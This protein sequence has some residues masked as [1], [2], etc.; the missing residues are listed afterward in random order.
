M[1]KDVQIII[2]AKDMASRALGSFGMALDTTTKKVTALD[3]QLQKTA[4]RADQFGR[5]AS[6]LLTAPLLAVG[7]ASVKAAADME[8]STIALTTLTGS[9][10]EANK[11]L[12]AIKKISLESKLTFPELVDASRKMLAY[13]FTVK[14]TIPMIKI[15]GDATSALGL[16]KE[17]IDR[18]TIALGQ[19]QAKSIVSAEEMRQLS[20]AGIGAWKYLADAIGVSVPEAM[21]MAEKRMIDGATGIKAILQGMANDPKF[22]DGMKKQADSIWGTWA[23]LQD[24]L[25]YSAATVGAV[26]AK[27]FDLKNRLKGATDW[28]KDFA[29]G[30]NKLNPA[31]KGTIVNVALFLVA[32][33]PVSMVV[34]QA[35]R[36]ISLLIGLL[37]AM[38]VASVVTFIKN[39]ITA[40][41][42]MTAGS[43]AAAYGVIF[44][45]RELQ[46][47]ALNATIV[48][49]IIGITALVSN[50]AD[51]ARICAIQ[52][53]N[54][55]NVEDA[56]KRIK[57]L[58]ELKLTLEKDLADQENKLLTGQQFDAGQFS[59]NGV[60]KYGDPNAV[61][62][63]SED[64]RK[65]AIDALK[66]RILEVD[67]MIKY[68]NVKI[69]DIMNPNLGENEDPA[70]KLKE[71]L[72]S[73]TKGLG[74]LSA[75]GGSK[76]TPADII[77]DLNTELTA[78]TTKHKLLG[79]EFD[80]ITANA[81][82]YKKAI[83]DMLSIDPNNSNL[84]EWVNK[85]QYYQRYSSIENSVKMLSDAAK[86]ELEWSDY[87][88]AYID[89]KSLIE[90][91]QNAAL[92][93][94][95]SV[96]A[97]PRYDEHLGAYVT[98]EVKQGMQNSVLLMKQ[99]TL[100]AEAEAERFK[101]IWSTSLNDTMTD[102]DNW[103]LHMVSIMAETAQ[104]MSDSFSNLFFDT[105]TG[106]FK[107]LSSYATSFVQSIAKSVTDSLGQM[108]TKNIMSGGFG[109][110]LGSQLNTVGNTAAQTANSAAMTAN[111]G[112]V[113]A[114][115][116]QNLLLTSSS[117]SLSTIFSSLTAAATSAAAALS[118]IAVT[119]GISG[120]FA[121]GGYAVAGNAY[122]VGERGPEVFVP[123][124]SGTVIPN[125]KL[126][127]LNS[128]SGKT[129]WNVSVINQTGVEAEKPT[130]DIDLET[131]QL[132]V[133]LKAVKTNKLGTRD[134]LKSFGGTR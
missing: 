77:K 48:G 29:D 32:V 127:P 54:L 2:S 37:E 47:L 134:V 5:S 85:M 60:S 67:N 17:G 92:Q 28:L 68:A 106:K 111:T 113:T 7:A 130:I 97:A 49:G 81:Q 35:A 71:F 91:L 107:S 9:A 52:I 55:N 80:V 31:V 3:S 10:A 84:G 69:R 27:T 24:Q 59:L 94:K 62:P 36:S 53:S 121:S 90:Q 39:Y 13:G 56:T 98:D 105:I 133:W 86:A 108:V 73:F 41:A 118:T 20:E 123:N 21:K 25:I 131:Q 102:W 74:D 79:S 14:Q 63:K 93:N 114:N 82:A 78:A 34:G 87:F 12:E 116:A 50:L 45:T 33:G 44:L 95:E 16:G 76:K 22:K 126:G 100:E 83:D 99:A 110:W 1:A 117:L 125:H 75:M 124:A 19:M 65:K 128:E 58:Q 23:N 11:Q 26:L 46:A 51:K 104:S 122:L 109:Q 43:E 89:K 38:K 42:G 18:V 30:F 96:L 8:Q 129:T 66:T 15:L 40:V 101:N 4:D 57:Y 88:G 115:T 119:G 64:D 61:K 120:A 132:T 112:A 103:S 72:N 70:A 6:L